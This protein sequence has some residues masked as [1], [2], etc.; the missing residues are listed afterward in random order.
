MSAI[1]KVK[2][3][4]LN[5]RLSNCAAV[6]LYR[7]ALGFTDTGLKLGHYDD[8]EDAYSMQLLL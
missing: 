6:A 7:E 2:Y 4:S 1:Y 3:V 5:V 8:G